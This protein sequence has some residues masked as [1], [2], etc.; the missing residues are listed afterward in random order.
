MVQYTKSRPH[1]R[2]KYKYN[3][4]K[5]QHWVD[6]ED[7]ETN[8]KLTKQGESKQMTGEGEL[9]EEC[10][11]FIPELEFPSGVEPAKLLQDEERARCMLL[12]T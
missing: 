3:D 4:K 9:P 11:Q 6:R 5:V 2:R 7:T 8:S 12:V 10:K 1:L